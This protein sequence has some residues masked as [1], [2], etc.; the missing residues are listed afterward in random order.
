[1]LQG[2]ICI[3]L[4]IVELDL[5]GIA[6][7]QPRRQLIVTAREVEMSEFS[8]VIH[9]VKIIMFG[10]PC[11]KIAV[12]RSEIWDGKYIPSFFYIYLYVGLITPEIFQID[13]HLIEQ[14]GIYQPVM[15]HLECRDQPMKTD[16]I[17][18]LEGQLP[19]NDIVLCFL[20]P[21][22]IDLPHGVRPG[23]IGNSSRRR[24]GWLRG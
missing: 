23:G 11:R 8:T 9:P 5:P 18:R 6:R 16:G 7:D 2:F 3:R 15:R 17:S 12:H 13:D 14:M 22:Y 4:I 1:M 21:R 24:K 19:F 20:V 10:R